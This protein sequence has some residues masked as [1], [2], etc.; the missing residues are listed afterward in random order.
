VLKRPRNIN[1]PRDKAQ[2]EYQRLQDHLL[3]MLLMQPKLRRQIKDCKIE[4]FTDGPQRHVFQF[5][6]NNPDFKGDPKIAEQ[7][8]ADGDYVKIL[9][10][11][12]EEMYQDLPPDDLEEQAG[13][14]KRRLIDR[15][16]KIQKHNL[17][18]AMNKAKSDK[19]LNSLMVQVDKLNVLIK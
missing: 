2:V 16:V 3:A 1:G 11:Q 15:Y 19:E 5:L 10:L 18:N 6:Q 8:Q 9:V 12:F 4:F 17:A 14:L 13:Q 7:L